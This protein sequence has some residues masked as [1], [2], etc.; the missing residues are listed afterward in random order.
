[1]ID[2]NQN[3]LDLFQRSY[4]ELLN[5]GPLPLYKPYA[6]DGT[7]TADMIADRVART[8][9]GETIVTE[10]M[11]VDQANPEGK[12]I[13]CELRMVQLPSSH[14]RLIRGSFVNIADR[15]EAEQSRLESEA[16]FRTLVENA[17]EAI[18]V[19][20]YET[21]TFV[22]VNENAEKLYKMDR[23]TLMTIGP[24]E[25]SPEYQPNGRKSVEY[26]V[27]VLS[28][29]L[30]GGRPVFEW[31]HQD[32]SGTHIPC[33]VRLVQLP[34]SD[35]I[36]IRASVIDITSRKE[37]ELELQKT[38]EQLVRSQQ[39]EALGRVAGGI[40]H[41]FN[42]ILTVVRGYSSLLV[43]D[44]PP[45]DPGFSYSEKILEA[46]ENA[47]SLTKQLLS[48]SKRRV[49]KPEIVNLNHIVG[50]VYNLLRRVIESSIEISTKLDGNLQNANIDA[51]QIEQVIINIV[52]NARDAMPN[53]GRVEMMTQ[54]ILD[55]HSIPRLR[56][57]PSNKKSFVLLSIKD[58]GIGMSD[59]VKNHVFEPFFTTK[60]SSKGS[61]LGLA[62]AYGIITQ[63]G[64]F[65]DVESVKGKGTEFKIYLPSVSD[66][67][68]PY[69]ESTEVHVLTEPENITILVVDD[70][71]D[72]CTVITEILT[73]SGYR[74]HVAN[75]PRKALDIFNENIDEIDLI[76]TDVVMPGMTG[77]ELIDKLVTKKPEL[78]VL[79]MTGYSQD[80]TLISKLQKSEFKALEKP[81]NDHVLIS[82]IQNLVKQ[83]SLKTT[84]L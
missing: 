50:K 77:P 46:T 72:I 67:V 49:L 22:D 15:K 26:I 62:I 33:E 10:V 70:E 17:P 76:I 80:V 71:E 63:S 52:I 23:G 75:D 47:T 43:N 59:D 11:V 58:D 19:I 4:D 34:S 44:L 45:S 64:G 21:G 54:N 55:P 79:F 3:A 78:K 60:E 38:K 41:D 25:V 31:T 51:A 30:E 74:V 20:D 24:V 42:N 29:S 40:A 13:P 2:A 6:P 73:R 56:N 83:R 48:V 7:P 65:I 5:M 68:E 27:D 8:L 12:E 35:R 1:F 37:A 16:R 84:K 32:V 53:G 82:T 81:F 36:L 57:E 9:S 28:Q 14:R 61:G 69:R 18:V 66:Q 39:L